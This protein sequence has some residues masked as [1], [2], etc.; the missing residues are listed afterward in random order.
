MATYVIKSAQLFVGTAHNEYGLAHEFRRE[1]I[2]RL[3]HLPVMPN[4]LPRSRK[5]L[6]LGREGIRL[7]IKVRQLGSCPGPIGIN[8]RGLKRV[9]HIGS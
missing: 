6:L 1:V 7:R 4:H 5:D 8:L 3:G 9:R 2:S